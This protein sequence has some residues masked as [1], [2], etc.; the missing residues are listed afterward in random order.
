[1]LDRRLPKEFRTREPTLEAWHEFEPNAVLKLLRVLADA[2]AWKERD[3]HRLRPDDKLWG[4]YRSYYPQRSW[5]QRLQPDELEMETLLRELRHEAP[6]LDIE[7][8]PD[9]TLA[10]LVRLLES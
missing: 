5:W 9:V 3:A 2:F 10:D 4:I 6:G 8:R 7:L 1:M